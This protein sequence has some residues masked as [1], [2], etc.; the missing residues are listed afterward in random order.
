[1]LGAPAVVG[2]MEAL[3][4]PSYVSPQYIEMF[5]RCCSVHQK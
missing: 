5:V 4:P 3:R 1:M 2:R